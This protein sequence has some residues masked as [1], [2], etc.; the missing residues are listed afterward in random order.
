MIM[1]KNFFENIKQ[2]HEFD[3]GSAFDKVT[4][5]DI[6][7]ALQ[8][9]SPADNDLIALISP[10]AD[11]YLE[12][13]AQK[14]HKLTLRHFGRT[15]QFYTPLYVSDYCD[16]V[17]VYCGFN[18]HLSIS[19]S[20]LDFDQVE[21]EAKKISDRGFR[22]VLLLTGDSR[23]KS[24]VA[25]IK[26]C[27]EILCRYFSSVSIEVYALE[28]DE[29]AD[30]ILSGVDGLTIYQETYDRGLYDRMHACGPKKDYSFRLLAPE[31]GARAGM[32]Q[33]NIGALFGLDNWRKELFFLAIHARFLQDKFTAVELGVSLPRLCPEA[34]GFRP[35]CSVADRDFVHMITALR[36]FLPRVGITIST[37]E[38]SSLRENIIPLGVTR[39][40]ADSSTVVGGHSAGQDKNSQFAIA[41]LRSL[42]EM[43]A[44]L[45][46]YNYQPVL[47]D[48]MTI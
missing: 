37:R 7:R 14:A 25:Y 30:L 47:H 1:R 17:C 20:R 24:P 8:T 42:N 36:V 38:H 34:G 46:K 21:T 29:Y 45:K 48:W 44:V 27:V 28:E 3:F 15:I 11:K 6:V 12:I 31:R 41:D 22:H 26:S 16:N 13:I 19:R 18:A 43:K 33:I 32:R 10:Q 9:D 5:K 35:L 23:E 40:S 2:W 39:F 4:E